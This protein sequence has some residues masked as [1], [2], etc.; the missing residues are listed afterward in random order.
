MLRWRQD[1]FK[2]CVMP[3]SSLFHHDISEQDSSPGQAMVSSTAEPHAWWCCCSPHVRSMTALV[4]VARVH[5]VR[6]RCTQAG[7]G[8]HNNTLWSVDHGRSHN[9]MEYKLCCWT[10]WRSHTTGQPDHT[11]VVLWCMIAILHCTCVRVDVFQQCE[12]L[13]HQGCH[14]SP[15]HFEGHKPNDIKL[16]NFA[17]KI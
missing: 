1:Q 17:F 9:R 12:V 5:H 8:M 3:A 7:S 14:M 16:H 15:E 11:H 10:R 13:H 4:N 2:C 6:D